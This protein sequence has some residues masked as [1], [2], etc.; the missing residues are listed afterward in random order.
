M[1]S[2]KG[3]K[4]GYKFVN[5]KLESFCTSRRWKLGR[6]YSTKR[7]TLPRYK[8]LPLMVF[9]T[10]EGALNY[11]AY[12]P[13][14]DIRLFECEYVESDHHLTSYTLDDDPKHVLQMQKKGRSD[15]FHDGTVFASRVKL[16]KEI[17]L[18]KEDRQ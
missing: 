14:E 8:E 11:S 18:D 6:Q 1:D 4:I 5:D 13:E 7:W 17:G 12:M 9:D 10:K 2:K 15:M 3:I 16:T